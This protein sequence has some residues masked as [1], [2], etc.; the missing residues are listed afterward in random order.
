[1]NMS[2]QE[3]SPC[4]SNFDWF[5]LP[6]YCSEANCRLLTMSTEVVLVTGGAGFI[7][8]HTVVELLNS[9]FQVVVV[10]DLSNSSEIALR[11]IEEITSKKIHTFYHINLIDEDRV[12]KMFQELKDKGVVITSVIHFAGNF[13]FC[14]MNLYF[15]TI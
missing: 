14:Y 3:K 10:D 15:N 6:F 13:I 9:G 8:S 4:Q 5:K 12:R 1:M 7:G 2:F 11:R